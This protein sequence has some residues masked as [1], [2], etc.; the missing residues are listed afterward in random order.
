MV[1]TI[2][3]SFSY[4]LNILSF[5]NIIAYILF[6]RQRDSQMFKTFNFD[7]FR[8][9][10]FLY[11]CKWNLC[12]LNWVYEEQ[13]KKRDKRKCQKPFWV[14]VPFSSFSLLCL[15]VCACAR[16]C[17]RISH[18]SLRAFHFVFHRHNCLYFRYT[19]I[20]SLWVCPTKTTKDKWFRSKIASK[21]LTIVPK[22]H[23]PTN[24]L[25]KQCEQ[26]RATSN[27]AMNLYFRLRLLYYI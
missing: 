3:N 19:F 22:T 14:L 15:F 18:S 16:V 27:K 8:C 2:I 6:N 13:Q 1:L 7:N 4:G 11:P 12:R 5:S 26:F 10:T 25:T 17:V 23:Q 21:R 24:Q 9:K 20:L